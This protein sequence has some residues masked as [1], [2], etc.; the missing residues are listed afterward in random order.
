MIIFLSFWAFQFLIFSFFSPLS[1]VCTGL[2]SFLST[3]VWYGFYRLLFRFKFR[4]YYSWI[5]WEFVKDRFL[6]GL[7]WGDLYSFVA[8]FFPCNQLFHWLSPY[9]ISLLLLA[10]IREGIV[11][12]VR[13]DRL[14]LFVVLLAFLFWAGV[15][16]LS[17]VV[18]KGHYHKRE[19]LGKKLNV[20]VFQTGI[21]ALDKQRI[22]LAPMIWE[23]YLALLRDRVRRT[24]LLVFPETMAIYSWPNRELIHYVDRLENML[25][26]SFIILGVNLYSD[27][28]FYNSALLIKPE[29]FS[30]YA[31]QKLVPFGEYIPDWIPNWFKNNILRLIP[32]LRN[33]QYS[34]GKDNVIFEVK[35]INV[36]PLICYEDS[37]YYLIETRMKK[38]RQ[39]IHALVVLSNDDWFGK[40]LAQWFHLNVAR[41]AAIRFRVWVIKANNDGFSCLIDPMGRIVT[42]DIYWDNLGKRTLVCGI[43]K[44]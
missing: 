34:R 13:R 42:G 38:I 16:Y 9:L 3:L 2:I 31:K 41:I 28:R 10:I 33:A 22:E 18:E 29:G 30:I 27:G 40:G 23:E 35:G 39:E 24:D 4:F 8:G 25:G 11:G 5:I 21:K 15:G 7:P 32:L 20:C 19:V 1:C 37:F 12:L 36:M 43:I 17:F 44:I 6:G 26:K 14:R